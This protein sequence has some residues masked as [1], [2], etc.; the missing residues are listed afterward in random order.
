MTCCEQ[1]HRLLRLE[2]TAGGHRAQ[3]PPR[4]ESV[5]GRLLRAISEDE[6][7]TATWGI[8][9]SV[10]PPLW[11][12][13]FPDV[14]LGFPLFRLVFVAPIL[15]LC[16]AGKSLALSC[17]YLSMRLLVSSVRSPLAF[18]QCWNLS[19]EMGWSFRLL[20]IEQSTEVTNYFRSVW[21][22]H[23]SGDSLIS[24]I[25]CGT[26]SSSL[27]LWVIKPPILSVRI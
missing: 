7:C 15:L 22:K 12:S 20:G 11:Q 2:G 9:P 25:A 27:S 6:D 14:W 16:I 1:N 17:L 10:V 3:Q 4:A 24:C 5:L 26:F 19:W 8:S 21:L 18:S 23:L 13:R